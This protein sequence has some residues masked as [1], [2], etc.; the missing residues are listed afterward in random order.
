M[1]RLPGCE[2][3]TGASTT[4]AKKL[5]RVT[6]K[7]TGTEEAQDKGREDHAEND[8]GSMHQDGRK[9][10]IGEKVVKGRIDVK[11]RKG[12]HDNRGNYT[13]LALIE[14]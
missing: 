11:R 6:G 10:G 5:S 9:K 13:E 3:K 1:R 14:D 2:K 8:S 4:G 7:K 12:L